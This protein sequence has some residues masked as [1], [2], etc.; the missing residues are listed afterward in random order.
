[1]K[2]IKI[3]KEAFPQA[4]NA[5]APTLPEIEPKDDLPSSLDILIR[6]MGRIRTGR[7]T[8]K[9]KVVHDYYDIMHD[10]MISW[11][12]MNPCGGCG[13]EHYSCIKFCKRSFC[14]CQTWS[15]ISLEE[16]THGIYKSKWYEFMWKMRRNSCI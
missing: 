3:S 12:T 4:R 6:R 15:N 11:K 1:M 2:V 16:F 14:G 9:F 8:D 5:I 13:H 7:S 10:R